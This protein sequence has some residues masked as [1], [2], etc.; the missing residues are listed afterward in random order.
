MI[1]SNTIPVPIKRCI[2]AASGPAS[3]SVWPGTAASTP[4]GRAAANADCNINGCDTA[5]KG[6]C[7][8]AKTLTLGATGVADSLGATDPLV[9]GNTVDGSSGKVEIGM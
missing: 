5:S 8:G 4:A 2:S 6:A 1:A 9:V 7:I 3:D